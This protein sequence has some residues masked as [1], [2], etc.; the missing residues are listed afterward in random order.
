[1][2]VI[3]VQFMDK[4]NELKD[5][6]NASAHAAS[7]GV[8]ADKQANGADITVKTESSQLQSVSYIT[9]L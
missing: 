1:M 2:Y 7:A 5:L 6:V 4:F 8:T 3:V 9:V